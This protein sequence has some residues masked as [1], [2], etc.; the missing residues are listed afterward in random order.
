MHQGEGLCMKG[1]SSHNDCSQEEFC[2]NGPEGWTDNTVCD[3]L[4]RCTLDRSQGP[5]PVDGECPVASTTPAPTPPV[6][7][8]EVEMKIAEPNKFKVADFVQEMANKTGVPVKNVNVKSMEMKMTVGY[9]LK[10]ANKVT[11]DQAESAIAK[12]LAIDKTQVSVEILGRRLADQLRGRRLSVETQMAATIT[13]DTNDEAQLEKAQAAHKKL[14]DTEK[15]ADMLKSVQ[16]NLKEDAGIEVEVPEVTDE[17]QVD[18]KV[19][20]EIEAVSEKPVVLPTGASLEEVA[21]QAGAD[22][23]EVKNVEVL[24]EAPTTTTTTIHRI[25]DKSRISSSSV[26]F[27]QFM[28]LTLAFAAPL[29]V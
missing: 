28:I 17:L 24:E 18:V 26:L 20:T 13:M 2:S 11:E 15:S 3:I 6:T 19:E 8:V 10:G 29:L 21:K 7:A 22:K 4:S 23:I 12:S 16:K 9:S 25:A 5:T 1:C 14:A 27:P